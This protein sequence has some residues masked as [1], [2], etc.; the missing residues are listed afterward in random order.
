M[1]VRESLIH[2]TFLTESRLSEIDWIIALSSSLIKPQNLDANVVEEVKNDPKFFDE[3]TP[4]LSDYCLSQIMGCDVN[5]RC[6]NLTSTTGTT[7]YLLTHQFLYYVVV[8]MHECHERF[9]DM[10]RVEERYTSQ[11][12]KILLEATEIS[13]DGLP[14]DDRE[15][16]L[17][18]FA[19]CGVSNVYSPLMCRWM[20]VI[21]TWQ[22]QSGCFDMHNGQDFSYKELASRVKRDDQILEGNCSEHKTAVGLG[23]LVTGL[24]YL[25]KYYA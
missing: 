24:K 17:E 9:G 23:A 8:L 21:V 16:F 15:L 7:G 4:S 14:E 18:Q 6:L 12:F 20:N 10:K 5:E 25:L 22:R 11:A 2:E 19:L 13:R 3:F 1:M